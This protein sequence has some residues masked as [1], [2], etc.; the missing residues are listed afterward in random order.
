[1]G[2]SLNALLS[3]DKGLGVGSPEGWRVVVVLGTCPPRLGMQE[4]SEEV[5]RPLRDHSC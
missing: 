4:T 2:W 1:M 5:N 3:R